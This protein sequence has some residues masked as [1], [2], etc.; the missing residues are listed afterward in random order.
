MNGMSR[1]FV[2][3]GLVVIM[4]FFDGRGYAR[5]RQFFK[6]RTYAGKLENHYPDEV[7]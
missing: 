3:L 1:V 4:V 6:Y 2:G 5:F 7:S